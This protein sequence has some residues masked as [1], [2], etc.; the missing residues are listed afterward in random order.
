[1]R[2]VNVFLY[3]NIELGKTPAKTFNNLTHLVTSATW[4]SSVRMGSISATVTLDTTALG[5]AESF[6]ADTL[7]R[8]RGEIQQAV[9]GYLV[10][11]DAQ[12]V[13]GE[14]VWWGRV[15]RARHRTRVNAQGVIVED[16][17]V[18]E[19]GSCL[20]VLAQSSIVAAASTP[21][22]SAVIPGALISAEGLG[23]YFKQVAEAIALQAKSV[24][25]YMGT[26]LETFWRAFAKN[27][28][29]PSALLN[30]AEGVTANALARELSEFDRLRVTTV[31]VGA[32]LEVGAP[33][34]AAVSAA[35]QIATGLNSLSKIPVVWN[36]PLALSFA[37]E[38]AA[39]MTPVPGWALNA[40]SGGV[41]RGSIWSF[42][43]AT[44]GA[45]PNLVEMFPSLEPAV[46]GSAG[47]LSVPG[48]GGASPVLNY[49]M[50]PL[51]EAP[52]P[53]GIST[54][55]FPSPNTFPSL[56]VIQASDITSIDT[57]YDDAERINGWFVHTPYK[58][59]SQMKLM[60]SWADPKF[61]TASANV[62]G[63]RYYEAN[64]P[65]YPGGGSL[66]TEGLYKESLSAVVEY[67]QAISANG[68][69]RPSGT[70]GLKYMP[71]VRAGHWYNAMFL[72]GRSLPGFYQ[73]Y[74]DTVTHS[75]RVDKKT[76]VQSGRSSMSFIR[77]KGAFDAPDVALPSIAA[78]PLPSPTP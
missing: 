15:Q 27:G 60:G 76:G 23:V 6:G 2:K 58:P 30:P 44:F 59:R 22:V 18:L 50:K 62:H 66:P 61:N 53:K 47:S 48:L 12:S 46:P 51:L 28:I 39:N 65:F 43:N 70:M 9:G 3:T 41:P 13:S 49:R 64:W 5:K 67:A 36:K 71:G 45:D 37:P 74:A 68:E 17:I 24:T 35:L 75:V 1:V 38:R 21:T 78:V 69:E 25:P 34:E 4:S 54:L 52:T 42:I 20:S 73:M 16:P 11:R 8:L 63:L 33:V 32:A 56:R 31:A 26:G 72:D 57:V 19:C 10:I 40:W 55:L 77:A 7:R 14:A 29:L